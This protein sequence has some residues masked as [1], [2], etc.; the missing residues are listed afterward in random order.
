MKKFNMEIAVGLFMV[1]GFL[2]F[3]YLSV[4]LGDVHPFGENKYTVIARFNSISG[5]KK[6]A[7]I[8]MAGV[9]IGKVKRIRLDP[10]E[11]E[12]VVQFSI[13]RNIKLQEDSI[14]SIR[15]EGIIGNRYINITPGGLDKIIQPGGEITETESAISIEELISKYIFGK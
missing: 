4:R 13:D 11:Y 9:P 7:S 8:E 5:L 6:G 10:K 15:T 3:T 12:A 14:A 1:A 2:C